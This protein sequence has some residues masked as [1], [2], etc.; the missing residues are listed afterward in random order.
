[1]FQG[2]IFHTTLGGDTN[3]EGFRVAYREGRPCDIHINICIFLIVFDELK[4]CLHQKTLSLFI[5]NVPYF[6][7]D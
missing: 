2:H 6:L 3:T 7:V 1:M 4:D 5:E